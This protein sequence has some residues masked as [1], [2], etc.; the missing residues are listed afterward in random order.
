MTTNGVRIRA[1]LPQEAAALSALALRSKAHWGYDEA[2]L[3]DCADD[4]RLAPGD[5]ADRRVRVAEAGGR[6]L[7]VATLDGEPPR[8]ELGMLFVDPMSIGRGVGQ[9][10][11]RHVLTE[12]G[13]L[14]CDR[15]T[16]TADSHAVP[17]YVAMG[18]RRAEASPSS[19][20]LVRMEAWTSGADPS[21]VRA[22][23]GGRRSVHLGNVAEFH[24]QFPGVAPTEGVPH[25]ACLSAFAGPHPAL[26][27]LPLPV[28]A[29]WMR[30]LARLLE[31]D[32][33]EVHCIDA[34]GGALTQALLGQPAL[35]R[36][37]RN[38]GLP[39]LPWGRTEASERLTSGPPLRLGH[40]SKAAS[41]RLFCTLAAA[42]PGIRVPAQE[43]VRSRRELAQ[44][45]AARASAGQTSV[46]KGEYGVGGSATFVLTP[47][48]VLSGGGTRAVTRR[49]FGEGLLVEEFVPGADLYRNPTFDGV[50]AEDGT[51]HVVG[52]GLMEVTGTAYRGVTVGPG[53]L[54]AE[55][56]A[57]ATA[58]GTA[59]GEALSAEGYQG[60]FDVDF[61]TDTAGRAA[62]TEI[63]LRLTGP[64]VAF[65]LQTRLDSVRG[66]RHLVR[67]LDCLP[68]GARLP[69]PAL[70]EHCDGLAR[71]CRA[72][73]AVLL[74]TIPTASLEPAPYVGVA[75]AARS[76]Q[77]LDE[78]EALV[79]FGN[80]ALSGSFTG[81]AAAATWASRRRT[82]RPRLR[83]S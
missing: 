26:V 28:E 74:T 32:E 8:A 48:D 29:A 61:V 37:I 40:E 53:V 67:T 4:L 75:L 63:N 71:R 57:T 51:V 80:G 77:A 7:G 39:V 55:L 24:A 27:V 31:W 35:T 30:G 69:A 2:Y 6:I 64:A 76:R 16:I 52:T 19:G 78:A 36:R 66:G 20:Q 21:W 44:A 46:V 9:L 41:H 83:R 14:G 22:W 38:S 17:F 23:T 68:L 1:G 42:H 11:Y 70:L 65:V 79:R 34:P 25:Y 12:A 82:R 18:A 60:W 45:L 43:P 81:P 3:A 50:I 73:G 62:P 10:L 54:P 5:M 59:V 33:V 58:F 15:V 56:T 13:R 49:L 72:L 47:E